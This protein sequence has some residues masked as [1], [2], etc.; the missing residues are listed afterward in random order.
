MGLLM[1]A[2][3]VGAALLAALAAPWE[4]AAPVEDADVHGAVALATGE[5]RMRGP[6]S[7]PVVGPVIRD[8]D[9]PETPYGPG[10]RGVDIA[11]AVGTPVRAPAAG[12]VVFA[13]TVGGERYVTLDHGGGLRSTY[14][15]LSA[16]SVRAGDVVA[17]GA[18]VGLSG[19]GHPGSAIPHLH[20]GVRLDGVYVDPLRY[21]GPAPVPEVVHLAPIPQG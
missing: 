5:E 16:I 11:V 4:R 9:P 8:F 20:L 18:P 17:A 12:E 7:W 14:S 21:L 19:W 13:G 1:R 3:V 15:W 6:W 2:C 10:H